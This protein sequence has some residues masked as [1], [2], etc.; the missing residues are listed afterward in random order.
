MSCLQYV[1]MMHSNGPIRLIEL[2]IY[3]VQKTFTGNSQKSWAV[4]L[5]TKKKQ[6]Q[7]KNTQKTQTLL[8]PNS[9]QRNHCRLK[10]YATNM[11][12]NYLNAYLTELWLSSK[13][14]G[15]SKYPRPLNPKAFL[16][17]IFQMFFFILSGT[18]NVRF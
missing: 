8:D 13:N 18:L 9:V 10:F 6:Q 17:N 15:H 2:G 3:S 12:S 1:V 14:F 11:I 16:C 5:F 7:K 4:C